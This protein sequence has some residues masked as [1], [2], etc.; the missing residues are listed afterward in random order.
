MR[1][2][3]FQGQYGIFEKEGLDLSMPAV[4]TCLGLYTESERHVVCA[5]F[6]TSLNLQR[7]LLDIK[8]SLE[9]KGLKMSDLRWCVFGGDGVLSY[10]RCGK[11]SSFIGKMIVDFIKSQGGDATY[12]N[13]HYSGLMENTFNFHYRNGSGS[14]ITEGKHSNDLQ[15]YH[16]DALSIARNRIKIHPEEYTE[17]HA[18]MTDV[19]RFYSSSRPKVSDGD[20]WRTES[21]VKKRSSLVKQTLSR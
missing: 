21:V 4:Q 2:V 9:D 15:G 17:K 14:E 8:K 18:A 12:S 16:P 11:P 3:I 6:D 10:L 19:S 7:N 20:N 13:E 1:A 5:H